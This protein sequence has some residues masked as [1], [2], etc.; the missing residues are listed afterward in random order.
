MVTYRD[1]SDSNRFEVMDFDPSID[2]FVAFVGALQAEGG[3]DSA[4]DLAGGV[5]QTNAL[6]WHH[7]TRLAF[8][9]VDYLCHG[10]DL[11]G[12]GIDDN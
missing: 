10:N 8:I 5:Q 1:L 6:S 7:P 12:G 11:N 4:E 3:D 9:I 2:K